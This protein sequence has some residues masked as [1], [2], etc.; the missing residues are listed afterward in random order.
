ME[1]NAKHDP[2][3]IALAAN[4]NYYLGLLVTASSIAMS[5][6][7]EAHLNF[8]ILDGGIDD[9]SF[10]ELKSVLC[11]AHARTTVCRHLINES[12]FAGLSTYVG[13]Y[14]AYVRL[15][16]PEL[17]SCSFV[18]Y[19]DVDF[20][21]HRDIDQLWKL[22]DANC[23][24]QVRHDISADTVE[25]ER[26]WFSERRLPFSGDAYFCSGLT[27]MNLDRF[28]EMRLKD[29]MLSFAAEYKTF[30]F[31]D[32]SILNAVAFRDKL[33]IGHLQREWQIFSRELTAEDVLRPFVVHYAGN[34]PWA[35]VV[36]LTDAELLWFSCLA[37]VRKCGIWQALKCVHAPI[38]IFFGRFLFWM[39]M[40]G[41]L[42][43]AIFVAGVRVAG[44]SH[45]IHSLLPL[46][47]RIPWKKVRF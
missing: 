21:W 24:M 36:V 39:A 19:C 9:L 6:N 47:T 34:T 27:L 13:N 11:R 40:M 22:R 16:L 12:L 5:V 33:A 20:L 31:A 14:M 8:H 30:N 17:L 46:L 18:I 25:K 10:N 38:N 29:A 41:V 28:R 26:V 32:Q 43:R 15:L 3:E 4:Q 1:N 23:V 45:R 35:K 7:P 44:Q 2:V 42:G 37:H